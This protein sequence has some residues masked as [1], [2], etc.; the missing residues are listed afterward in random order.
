MKN[1]GLNQY[2]SVFFT[3]LCACA[4]GAHS[5][6]SHDPSLI[7]GQ[8]TL[9]SMSALEFSP[10]GIL[11]IGDSLQGAIVSVDLQEKRRDAVAAPE[12]KDLQAQIA[13]LMGSK[14]SDVVIH[15]LAVNPVSKNTYLSVSRGR[16]NWRAGKTPAD[17]FMLLKVSPDSS[18]EEVNLNKVN[19]SKAML[20][21]P[22]ARN[23]FWSG[24]YSK[25]T[26]AIG[27]LVYKQGKLYVSGM[28]NEDFS[29]SMWTFSYPFNQ[30][31]KVSSVEMFH[32]AHGQY[33]TRSP[34][35]TFMPY[36]I[37]NQQHML[38]AYACTPLV[39][40][41]MSKLTD[42][43]HVKGT[44]IAELGAGNGP[45]DIISYQ[46]QGQQKIL[47]SNS[48]QP[49]MAFDPNKLNAYKGSM[50]KRARSYTEGFAFTSLPQKGV[51]QLDDFNGDLVMTTTKL[52]NGQIA[53]T[54]IKKALL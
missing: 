32:G 10:Q 16:A 39:T 51:Q 14:A 5:N 54:G 28:S 34:I 48:R 22:I 52:A 46:Y 33:E 23:E 47:M 15:D 38:A 27:N 25:R 50:T 37:N 9:E 26:R 12:I 2:K 18:I 1:L 45:I 17:A 11:F 20:P 29:S 19:Y 42:K 31:I 30:D 49:L 3:L 13:A 40:I 7:S 44:T 53:L 41:P 36:E 21:N 24:G 35:R 6:D 43:A 4:T 8:P